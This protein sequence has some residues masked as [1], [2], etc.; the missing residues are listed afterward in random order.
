MGSSV[1]F[2]MGG[3]DLLRK[4]DRLN[5]KVSSVPIEYIENPVMVEI[6]LRQHVGTIAKPI[7]D[8]GDQVWAGQLIAQTESEVETDIEYLPSCIHSSIDGIVTSI[9][10]RTLTDGQKTESIVIEYE[11]LPVH[12][13]S[14]ESHHSGKWRGENHENILN[15]IAAAGIVGMGGAAFPTNAKLSMPIQQ[16]CDYLLLNAAECEPYLHS[17]TSLLAELA[18]DVVG[19]IDILAYILKP[20]HIVIGLEKHK[21]YLV[22]K[23]T[24]AIQ[25]YRKHLQTTEGSSELLSPIHIALLKSRYPQG[26][27][28]QLVQAISGREIPKGKL[29]PE[30][31]CL[32]VNVATS[33]SIFDAVEHH[34]PL[35]R[36]I[37]TVNG[38]AV[39]QPKVFN[40]PVGTPISELL[41]R[42]NGLTQSVA[43]MINGGPMMGM[44]FYNLQQFV[45]KHS[46]GF[47]FLNKQEIL[48][49]KELPCIRCDACIQ[50][51]PI[52]LEPAQM[53]RHIQ[54]EDIE[55]AMKIGLPHCI[56][57]GACVSVCPSQ[58]PLT[59]GF[60]I[61]KM[62]W[63]QL[64]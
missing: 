60:R 34:L 26:A 27:E 47:L 17:D 59:Q 55:S 20:R 16:H 57:C 22:S 64:Q 44:S 51:C 19:G 42:C 36:R 41:K 28:R 49:K 61:G 46:N 31:G 45:T 4:K 5:S 32:V 39:A 52:G 14:I 53:Y 33:K 15:L 8:I 23:I 37:V 43:R 35:T 40:A 7:V 21:A 3:V 38:N 1:S 12:K 56:E 6:F 11:Q 58:I 30:V 48:H 50:V 18:F 2:S 9:E 62:R 25:Q 54:I 10:N 13:N 24:K 29:P 63:Q